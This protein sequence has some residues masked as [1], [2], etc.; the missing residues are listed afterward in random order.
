VEIGEPQRIWIVEP[1][2]EPVHE[3]EVEEAT[4][5]RVEPEPVAA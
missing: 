1:A 5:P 3:V 2:E 4:E